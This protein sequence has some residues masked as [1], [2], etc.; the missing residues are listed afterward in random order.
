MNECENVQKRAQIK[1][2]KTEK[3]KNKRNET[4]RK[5]VNGSR[6]TK[7]RNCFFP[8][9]KFLCWLSLCLCSMYSNQRHLAIRTTNYIKILSLFSSFLMRACAPCMRMCVLRVFYSFVCLSVSISVSF[10]SLVV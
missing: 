7:L 1:K 4:N 10:F 2:K 6:K 5:S 3:Q 9:F 8:R